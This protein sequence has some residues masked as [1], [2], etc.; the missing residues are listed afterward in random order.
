MSEDT[1]C[2]NFC[3]IIGLTAPEVTGEQDA[4][5]LGERAIVLINHSL[6]L[7]C[8][9]VAALRIL[10][11]SISKKDSGRRKCASVIDIPALQKLLYP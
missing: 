1:D 9:E 6:H 2:R 10:T 11:P 5:D 8:H 3:G 4:E 7:L